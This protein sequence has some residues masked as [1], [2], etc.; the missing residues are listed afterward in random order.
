[1]S[2]TGRSGTGQILRLDFRKTGPTAWRTLASLSFSPHPGMEFTG[3]F[4]GPPFQA[5][6][7]LR[8]SWAGWECREA[9]RYHR[10]LGRTWLSGIGFSHAIGLSRPN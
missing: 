8:F 3:G 6:L 1:L 10:Y 2:G 9:L 7:G 5:A 4:A